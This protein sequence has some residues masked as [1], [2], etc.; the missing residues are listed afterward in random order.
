M[1]A[2]VEVDASGVVRGG[3]LYVRKLFEEYAKL[4][5]EDRFLIFGWA[6]RDPDALRRQF[7]IPDSP[8]VGYAIKRWPQS[9]VERLQFG[10]GVPLLEWEMK[11]LGCDV[12]H[13]FRVPRSGKVAVVMTVPDV[14]PLV[15]PDLYTPEHVPFWEGR[16]KPG[17]AAAD[18]LVT[19][20]ETTKKHL[21]ELVGVPPEKVH[22]TPLGVDPSTFHPVERPAGGERYLIMV[23]PFDVLARFD[24]VVEAL[25][26]W[27]GERPTIVCVGP[28]DDYVRGL[29]RLAAEKGVADCFRWPGYMPQAKLVELYGRSAGLIY[30]S[31]LPGVELPPYEAMAC[32]IPVATSLGEVI[33]DAG[34]LIDEKSPAS[35]G[36][37]MKKLWESDAEAERLRP[38]ALARAAQ[39]TW[40]RCAETTLAAYRAALSRRR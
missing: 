38:K 28:V 31:K 26:A 13:G 29:Q 21:V 14:W 35:I 11:R 27:K 30:P 16:V 3:T 33:A 12:Y 23:G 8:R 19:Y 5:G 15:L 6:F 39:F 17:I 1:R 24:N 40:K 20:A 37:A 22:V 2:A 7:P 10:L 9:L 36:A 18:V 25:A 34:I 4:P 32:G